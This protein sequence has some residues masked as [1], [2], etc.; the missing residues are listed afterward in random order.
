MRLRD[1]LQE[2]YIISVNNHNGYFE[3]FRN[4]GSSEISKMIDIRMI[5]VKSSKEIWVWDANLLHHQLEELLGNKHYLKIPDPGGKEHL[6]KNPFKQK[7]IFY[8][9]GKKNGTKI[10]ITNIITYNVSHLRSSNGWSW[11]SKFLINDISS[12]IEAW[13]KLSKKEQQELKRKEWINIK[14]DLLKV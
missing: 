9:T 11:S 8:A 4:P 6:I 12:L 14:R 3:I 5:L 10:E 7:D 1:Y 2:E 13:K